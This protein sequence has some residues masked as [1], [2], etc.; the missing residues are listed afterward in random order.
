MLLIQ[1]GLVDKIPPQES[2]LCT[3]DGELVVATP[4]KV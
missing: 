1:E 3:V 2:L 4:L